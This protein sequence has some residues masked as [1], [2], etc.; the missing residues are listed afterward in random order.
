MPLDAFTLRALSRELHQRLAGGRID[1][2][3]QPEKD[4]VHLVIRSQGVNYRLLL[5]SSAASPRVHLTEDVKPNPLSAP[6]FCMLLRKKLLGGQI[7][8]VAQLGME[9]ILC[10]SIRAANELGVDTQ[11]TLHCEIMGRHSNIILTDENQ[12]ILE[13]IK[14]VGEDRSRV[15]EV[16]PGLVYQLPPPV[17][18]MDPL[19]MDEEDFARL[20]S[21]GDPRPAAQYLAGHLAG[22]SLPTARLLAA[23]A[24]SDPDAPLLR[25]EEAEKAC[26]ARYLAA[27]YRRLTEGVCQPLLICDPGQDAPLDFTAAPNTLYPPDW[28]HPMSSLSAAMDAFYRERDRAERMRERTHRMQQVVT[29]VL[30]RDYRKLDK[31]LRTLDGAERLQEYRLYGELLTAY[32]QLAKKGQHSVEVPNYYEEDQ[33]PVS[34]PLDPTKG[35]LENANAYYKKYRKAK[36]ALDLVKAQMAE[37]Q[38]EIAYL[39]SV[40]LQLRQCASESEVQEIHQELVQQGYLKA[41][42]QKGEK[43]LPPSRPLHYISE[44]G[45]DIYVGRNNQQ[46][47]QLT[48]RFARGDDMWLHTQKIP[49]SHVI[50]KAREGSVSSTALAQAILLAAWYSKAQGSS[51]IP[52]DYT[53]KKY[54]KKPSGAKPGFVIYTTQQTAYVT[55]EA[56][57]IHSMRLAED[58]EP[59]RS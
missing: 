16:L 18:R 12:R 7:L 24:L 45:Y 21:A 51:S 47:D 54:V 20:L 13:C 15:R 28:A 43:R 38:E 52:V 9:R 25:L 34:I 11:L 57:Q 22:L 55:P 35:P 49:G 23:G 29:T 2:V 6:M 1:K 30:E 3:L 32:Q 33:K 27:Q 42:R 36:T 19:A 44:D 26:L 4:E 48:L 14:H 10:I 31:Q 8:S 37:N 46:N 58:A 53:R 50:V 17:D 39:E 5:S 59:R 56:S 41:G 40:S